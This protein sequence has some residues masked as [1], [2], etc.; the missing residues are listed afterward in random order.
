[1]RQD[2]L[3]RLDTT[4]QACFRRVQRVQRGERAGF[5]RFQGRDRWHSFTYKEY[6]NGAR[7]ENGS[8]VLATIGRLAV[9]WSRPLQ[10]IPKTVTLSREADG[11][12]VAIS[13]AEGPV[14]PLPLTGHETGIDLGLASFATRAAGSQLAT[15]RS[16]RVAE[17]ALR[18][19]QRRVARRTKGSHRRKKAVRL[20]AR[21]HQTVRRQRQDFHPKTAR[22]M[23]QQYDTVS[24]EALPTAN[25][26]KNHHL[27]QSM[28]FLSTPGMRG[29]TLASRSAARRPR[30]SPRSRRR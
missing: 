21:A 11:W 24:H 2:V 6:G 19:A 29:Y 15:P 16:F 5:P 22:A 14:H 18:R 25:M 27:A 28:A 1:M 30:G 8:L 12:Y 3:A 10:G 9:R 23:V 17:M 7:R 20:L 13:C 26:L 4:A